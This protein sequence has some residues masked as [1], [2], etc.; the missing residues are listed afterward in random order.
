LGGLLYAHRRM[1]QSFKRSMGV[2]GVVLGNGGVHF[3]SAEI[4]YQLYNSLGT[5]A[6]GEF[7]AV[8]P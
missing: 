7:A 8:P 6:G 5:R 1:W 2:V 4:D 3:L